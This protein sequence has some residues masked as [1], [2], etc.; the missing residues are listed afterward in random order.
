MRSMLGVLCGD[1]SEDW[2]EMRGKEKMDSTVGNEQ[3][4]R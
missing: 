4:I 1:L 2:T 3:R